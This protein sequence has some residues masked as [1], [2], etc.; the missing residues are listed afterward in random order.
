VATDQGIAALQAR[1]DRIQ[2]LYNGDMTKAGHAVGKGARTEA[3][4][5][6]SGVTG[7]DG[8][9]SHMGRKGARLGMRYDLADQGRRVTIKLTPAGPWVLTESGAKPHT[10]KPKSGRARGLGTGWGIDAAVWSPAYDHPTRKPFTH[11]GTRG[12]QA[13]RAITRT[14]ARVRARAS[15][16]FHDAYLEQLAKVMA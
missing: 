16:D 11:P 6:A 3:K 1:L 5:V 8:V 10:I 2:D 13:R 14:F 15:R 7:G 12:R 4:D 9:L